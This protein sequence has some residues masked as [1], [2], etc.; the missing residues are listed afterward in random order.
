MRNLVKVIWIGLFIICTQAY[1]EVNEILLDTFENEPEKRW[2][3]FADTV[4][5][6]VSTGQVSFRNEN[7]KKYARMTGEVSTKNRGGFIQFRRTI[8]EKYADGV[9]GVRLIVRGNNQ[10][11]FVHLRTNGTILPWQYYQGNFETTDGWD[12]IRIPLSS[13]KAS[14]RILSTKIRAS[15]LKSI[16]IVAYGRNHKAL[17]DILEIGFY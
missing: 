9:K 11:Y 1:A 10:Q 5:G 13:F 6:G 4:M 12:E 14:G 2:E 15:S 16:G 3:F 8:S 7:G 17:V